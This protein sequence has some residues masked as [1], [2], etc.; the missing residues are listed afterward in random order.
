MQI[1]NLMC[2]VAK[3][4][5]VTY[6]LVVLIKFHK[7]FSTYSKTKEFNIRKT[8]ESNRRKSSISTFDFEGYFKKEDQHLRNTARFTWEA[9]HVPLSVSVC[10]NVPGYDQPK[11][12]VSSDSLAIRKKFSNN[13]LT[14]WW[15]SVKRV[16]RYCYWIAFPMC[17]SK[18]ID[19]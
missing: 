19:E 9:E 14:I 6:F 3:R 15:K 11:C 4:L 2:S 12:F 10:C 17:S 1:K 8:K 5:Y 16:T 18:L 13:L 7:P